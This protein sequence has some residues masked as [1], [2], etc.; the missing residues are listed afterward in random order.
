MFCHLFIPQKKQ[1]KE[2]S[3]VSVWSGSVHFLS[4]FVRRI[5][6]R[7][8][9]FVRHVR[10]ILCFEKFKGYSQLNLHIYES[11]KAAVPLETHAGSH[12]K[13]C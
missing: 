4:F 13:L 8:K 6:A 2:K 10:V 12:N 1:L 9:S 3:A 11:V 7:N 5:W